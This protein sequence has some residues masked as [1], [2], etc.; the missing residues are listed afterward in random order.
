MLFFVWVSVP[1]LGNPTDFQLCM[2]KS[3]IKYNFLDKLGTCG[4]AGF[5]ILE[6]HVSFNLCYC[7]CTV[8]SKCFEIQ[9][10][11]QIPGYS[12]LLKPLKLP[13][14]RC[15]AVS[16]GLYEGKPVYDI[17]PWYPCPMFEC[18]W[19]SS[20]RNWMEFHSA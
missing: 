15:F 13:S 3:A 6:G 14:S 2:W 18:L 8:P 1:G 20:T 5:L 17:L 19:E 7:S 9:V 10:N 16:I 4:A 11:M 12:E